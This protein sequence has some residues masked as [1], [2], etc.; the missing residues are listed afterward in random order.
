M[1]ESYHR[2][3]EISVQSA[4]ANRSEGLAKSLFIFHSNWTLSLRTS[5]INVEFFFRSN[6]LIQ[7]L[8]CLCIIFFFIL[9]IIY[10]SHVSVNWMASAHVSL[11]AFRSTSSFAFFCRIRAKKCVYVW[12]FL[13]RDVWLNCAVL[14]CTENSKK[15]YL[16]QKQK[17]KKTCNISGFAVNAWPFLNY[18][19][20]KKRWNWYSTEYS[21]I[22]RHASNNWRQKLRKKKQCVRSVT[23]W[24]VITVDNGMFPFSRRHPNWVLI[25]NYD[26]FL[27]WK[28]YCAFECRK[29]LVWRVRRKLKAAVVRVEIKEG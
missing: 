5:H 4:V 18:S 3:K 7:Q 2:D 8:I 14:I 9:L 15:L 11:L 20:K 13:S 29:D 1:K 16:K 23:R 24:K 19:K 22:R 12:R 6:I 27:Y 17:K 25:S 21:S 28:F 26:F 10:S